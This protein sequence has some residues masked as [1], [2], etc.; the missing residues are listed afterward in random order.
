MGHL[1][2]T[3]KFKGIIKDYA[4]SVTNQQ[5]LPRLVMTLQVTSLYNPS[6]ETWESWE[7][8]ELTTITSYSVLVT[9]D[10]KT[11]AVVKCLNYDQVMEAVGW[12]G[13]S[14][15]GLA[16]MNL[17]DK[18]IQFSAEEHTYEGKTSVRV[19]WL[20]A[21]DAE[22]G[23]R[24]LDDKDL[25]ALDAQFRVAPDKKKVA[26]KP[27]VKAKAAT[28]PKRAAPP[29]PPKAAKKTA[30]APDAYTEACTE[31]AAFKAIFEAVAAVNKKAGKEVIPDAVRDDWW[32]ESIDEI[33]ANSDDP[34]E[35]EYGRIRA[36]VLGKISIT[37]TP[38]DTPS[39][40]DIPF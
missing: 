24:K 14:F 1:E 3:G 2:Q 35:E 26:A 40:D 30:G 28:A 36:S 31:E 39:G 5:K 4:V 7:E 11:Q 10:K 32:L 37:G 27:K 18:E 34:T 13:E 19:N 15:A 8:Y 33:A 23:L 9:L 20:A 12:D 17:R 21:V 25:A 22:M 38:T 16:A 6:T 29:K